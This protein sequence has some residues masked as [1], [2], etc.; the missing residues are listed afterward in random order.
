MSFSDGLLPTDSVT[1]V[2]SKKLPIEQRFRLAKRLLK[3]GAGA[4]GNAETHSRPVAK[5]FV[6]ALASPGRSHDLDVE[7][8]PG[9]LPTCDFTAYAYGWEAGQA[10]LRVVRSEERRSRQ[11]KQNSQPHRRR[12]KLASA[13]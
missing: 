7:L 1:N 12:R 6:E 13:A 4:L 3:A 11:Q 8:K 10:A 9:K 2:I 5:G